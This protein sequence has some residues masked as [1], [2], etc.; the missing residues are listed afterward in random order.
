MTEVIL[1]QAFGPPK[2]RITQFPSFR[3]KTYLGETVD[4]DTLGQRIISSSSRSKSLVHRF[5][6][7]RLADILQLRAREQ[8][9]D[10]CFVN[11]PQIV[12]LNLQG[13]IMA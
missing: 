4:R 6:I 5:S 3:H 1:V 12:F 9:V 2:T 7:L 11:F 8:F 13:D 10:H